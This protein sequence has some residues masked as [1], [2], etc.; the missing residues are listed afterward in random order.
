MKE[1]NYILTDLE[2]VDPN[3]IAPRICKCGCGNTF[4]PRS[5]SH[6]YVNKKHG[7]FGYYHNVRKPKQKN[8]ILIQK[9]H[10][11]NDRVCKKYVD[12]SEDGIAICNWESILAEGLNDAFTHGECEESG[13]R[14][15]LT[16]NYMYHVFKENEIIKV[17]IK[18]Q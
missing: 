11:K 15:V 10:R 13:V 1:E 17:K 6:V 4:Q 3:P 2:N 5:I 16:Y 9:I 8:Q 7:D 18:K 14:Y 12:F